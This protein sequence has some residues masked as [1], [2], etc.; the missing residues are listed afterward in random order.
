MQVVECLIK[1][2][3]SCVNIC[4]KDGTSPLHSAIEI[5]NAEAVRLL[6]QVM[7]R[8]KFVDCYSWFSNRRGQSLT[9]LTKKGVM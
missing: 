7:V 8:G 4:S 3:Q 1:A 2:D 6:V 5:G 9:Q